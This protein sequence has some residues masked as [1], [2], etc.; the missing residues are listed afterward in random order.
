MPLLLRKIV[1]AFLFGLFLGSCK[2]TENN[3]AVV[4]VKLNNTEHNCSL[5]N[6]SV[7]ENKANFTV[8]NYE[9]TSYV[10]NKIMFW[11]IP[12]TPGK[13]QFH[14]ITRDSNGVPY[15][16]PYCNFFVIVG[17][18]AGCGSWDVLNSDSLNNYITIDSSTTEHK[19]SGTFSI[20]FIKMTPCAGYP[21]TLRFSKGNF[22]F[23]L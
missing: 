1:S 19:V 23:R 12:I 22:S 14:T 5:I 13:Y 8:I 20:S 15:Q 3:A 4:S 10:D 17:G 18:D 9:R 6:Y 21:D 11:E 16:K 2:K 7:K